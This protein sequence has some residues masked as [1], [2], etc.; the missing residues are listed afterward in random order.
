[1]DAKDAALI[2]ANARMMELEAKLHAVERMSLVMKDLSC[3]HCLAL[4]KV[5]VTY[6][7]FY[8]VTIFLLRYLR[9]P[10]KKKL[11]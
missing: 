11:G 5:L 9:Q 8:F 6:L 7:F 2:A 4:L 1:M 3:N 10:F